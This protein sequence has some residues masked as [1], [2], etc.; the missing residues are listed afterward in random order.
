MRQE[1]PPQREDAIRQAAEL[2]DAEQCPPLP[3]DQEIGY[4]RDAWQRVC[5]DR[6]LGK[7]NHGQRRS[8][9]TNNTVAGT[10]EEP[11]NIARRTRRGPD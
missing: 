9:L 5:R 11:S 6:S 3:Q 1:R 10:P 8:I 2:A 4:G 7:R